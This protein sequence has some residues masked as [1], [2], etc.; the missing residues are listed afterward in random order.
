MHAGIPSLTLS[1]WESSDQLGAAQHVSHQRGNRREINS[2][3][4]NTIWLR[5][6]SAADTRTGIYRDKT[7]THPLI[8]PIQAKCIRTKRTAVSVLSC[9]RALQ[10]LGQ[11]V[12]SG[13][14]RILDSD[15][16]SRRGGPGCVLV[17][18]VRSLWQ[19][20]S[21]T[22][23]CMWC[24]KPTSA[25]WHIQVL[26]CPVCAFKIRADNISFRYEP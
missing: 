22:W 13:P 23:N 21:G 14:V 16:S 18:S 10:L 5:T 17:P 7:L 11:R 26:T 20:L 6:R 1:C 19:E 15:P 3:W 12:L 4:P 9:T 25:K 24:W 2:Q 8:N